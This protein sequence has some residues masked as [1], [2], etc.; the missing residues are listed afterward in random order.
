MRNMILDDIIKTCVRESNLALVAN[1][2][3]RADFV[4]ASTVKTVLLI[5]VALHKIHRNTPL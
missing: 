3:K 5:E 4:S 2:H 1:P